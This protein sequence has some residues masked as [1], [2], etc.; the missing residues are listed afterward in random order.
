MA[1]RPYFYANGKRKSSVATVRLYPGGRG[2]LTINDIG[3]R[4]WADTEEM[5]K[6]V[7]APL[8][9][10]GGKGDRD[11]AIRTSGGGKRAQAD[12]ARLGIARALTKQE[13]DLRAQL[14]E[15]GYLTRD[16]RTKERKKPGLR[17]ARRAPQFSKR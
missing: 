5:I 8:N 12:A 9:T 3:L 1:D 6:S 14:K 2:D 4:E 10:I 7:L 13:P 15:A 17:G 11:F 16:S